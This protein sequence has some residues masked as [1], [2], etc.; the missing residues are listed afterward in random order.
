MVLHMVAKNP[1]VSVTLSPEDYEILRRLSE[2]NGESMS[3]IIGELVQAVSPALGRVVDV[4]EVAQ[5]AKPEVLEQLRRVAEDSERVMSPILQAGME[6]FQQF[7]DR[8][9]DAARPPAL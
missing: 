4:V 3:S 8:A 5:G 6:G 9:A 7:A 1:R 2:L